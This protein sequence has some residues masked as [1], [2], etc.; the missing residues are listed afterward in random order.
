LL[1]LRFG[2][3]VATARALLPS[4]EPAGEGDENVYRSRTKLFEEPA[5]CNFGFGAESTLSRIECRIDPPLEADRQAA[6]CEKLLST[7][8]SLYGKESSQTP[9][10]ELRRWEW[11]NE[12]AGLSLSCRQGAPAAEGTTLFEVTNFSRSPQSP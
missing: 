11:N 10:M 4:L 7:L 8:K 2:M 6:L 1:G 5:T 9:A 3:T 12:R